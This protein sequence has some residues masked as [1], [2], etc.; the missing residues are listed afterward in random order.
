LDMP[1]LAGS[2]QND[3]GLSPRYLVA[4]VAHST[5]SLGPTLFK[6][7][8]IS[9]RV[10]ENQDA[11]YCARPGGWQCRGILPA[12]ILGLVRNGLYPRIFVEWSLTDP[13]AEVLNRAPTSFVVAVGHSCGR[14]GL[15]YRNSAR[16]HHAGSGRVAWPLA[17]LAHQQSQPQA[18]GDGVT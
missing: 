5:P 2:I 18:P 13:A 11:P 8:R 3:S 1:G 9:P 10:R 15:H 12:N 4:C 17:A 6:F 7:E 16:V 14:N